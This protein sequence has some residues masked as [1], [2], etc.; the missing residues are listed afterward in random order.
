MEPN[1][2]GRWRAGAPAAAVSKRRS[3]HQW[4]RGVLLAHGRRGSGQHLTLLNIFYNNRA[5]GLNR[6]SAVYPNFIDFYEEGG[7]GDI[8]GFEIPYEDGGT[9]EHHRCRA[10]QRGQDR[11][12]AAH[13]LE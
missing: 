7:V 12:G 13:H 3:G 9:L 4:R 11:D 5:P 2:V 6:A 1:P 8:I 10:G